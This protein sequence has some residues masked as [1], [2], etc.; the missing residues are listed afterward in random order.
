[1]L[2]FNSHHLAFY[3]FLINTMVSYSQHKELLSEGFDQIIENDKI[4]YI[5]HQG[6]RNPL[7]SF[8]KLE[9][10]SKDL[11][12][13]KVIA[14]HHMPIMGYINEGTYFSP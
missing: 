8:K 14:Y 11:P 13:A 3:L 6:L 2:R 5:E 7:S 10:Y 1:M 4:V 9:E 12:F